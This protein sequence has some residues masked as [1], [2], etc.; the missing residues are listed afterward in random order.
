[1]TTLSPVIAG[2][3]RLDSWSW[4]PAETCRWI[5]ACADLGVTSFDH[6]DIYGGFAAEAQFG[7]ALALSPGLR[8][9]V[10]LLTKCG[11]SPVS[12]ARQPQP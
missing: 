10:Q 3:W 5:E 7:A 9:R 11:I 12:P 6:A 8:D 1:M 2:C 4:S